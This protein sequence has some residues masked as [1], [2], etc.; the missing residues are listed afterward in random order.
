MNKRLFISIPLPQ[1]WHDAFDAFGRQYG[2]RDMRWTSKE[3]IHITA[4]FLGDVDEARIGEI[5]EKLKQV[6]TRTEP[7]SLSFGN[8]SFAPPGMPSRMVWAVFQE[9]DAYAGLVKDMQE[10][11]LS[12]LA[13]EPHKELIPHTTLARFKNPA[14]VNEIDIVKTQL[15]LRSFEAR[16]VELMESHL[17]PVGVRYEKLGSFLFGAR[18]KSCDIKFRAENRDIF[19]AIRD[20]RKKIETRAATGKYRSI[21]KGDVVVL[22]CEEESF[23]KRVKGIE[24]FDSIDALLKKH[25]PKDINPKCATEED[26]REMYHS[27]PDYEENIKKYG[28]IALELE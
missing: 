27:F 15:A 23:E 18:M 20:G 5:Q 28:L 3:N 4:C 7:F 13:V 17:D 6:C 2:A 22:V 24:L 25:K 11:L 19:Q 26:I 21:K 8:I 12:F 16:S 1:E 9:S 14:L 10:A